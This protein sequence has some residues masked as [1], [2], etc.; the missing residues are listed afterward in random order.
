MAEAAVAADGGAIRQLAQAEAAV[1]AFQRTQRPSGLRGHAWCR[2]CSVEQRGAPRG[3][4]A[5]GL[6]PNRARNSTGLRCP[7]RRWEAKEDNRPN[8]LILLLVG[9]GQPDLR[10]VLFV[11][12]RYPDP[13]WCWHTITRALE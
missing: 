13:L 4:E 5:I 3:L 1:L 2:W 9:P 11:G 8:Q 12:R 7:F 6:P 10:A